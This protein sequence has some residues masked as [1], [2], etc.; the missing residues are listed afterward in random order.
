M[1][2]GRGKTKK[3]E[4][5]H[6]GTPE[7][8]TNRQQNA[9]SNIPWEQILVVSGIE[10][11]QSALDSITHLSHETE[12]NSV[13]P[14][15]QDITTVAVGEPSKTVTRVQEK[16]QIKEESERMQE[17]Q[18]SAQMASEQHHISQ[19]GCDQPKEKK[20]RM[21]WPDYAM[22]EAITDV[23]NG[24]SIRTAA[25]KY[26][27]PSSSLH[28]RVS[29]KKFGKKRRKGDV[30]EGMEH[31][32]SMVVPEK[33]C[34][35]NN[36]M[37]D[38][39]AYG[40]EVS[41]KN[42]E[43]NADDRAITIV[44]SGSCEPVADM[45][46]HTAEMDAPVVEV[47]DEQITSIAE[48]ED[49][50][51]DVD[52][53]EVIVDTINGSGDDVA[54][55]TVP[56]GKRMR[57]VT[58]RCS[59]QKGQRKYKWSNEDMV[60]A[61]KAVKNGNM[62]QR[63]AAANYNVPFWT[64][65]DRLRGKVKM[66]DDAGNLIQAIRCVR[67]TN[68]TVEDMENAI[69][70]VKNGMSQRKAAIVHG[71]PKSSLADRITGKRTISSNI[72]TSL[73]RVQSAGDSCEGSSQG[74]TKEA[75]GRGRKTGVK[76][77]IRGT[78]GK[79]VEKRV[80][81]SHE[82]E[83][84]YEE[85]LL[86]DNVEV[87]VIDEEL[88]VRDLIED[89]SDVIVRQNE[90]ITALNGNCAESR[91]DPPEQDSKNNLAV[92]D[93]DNE[94]RGSEESAV[95]DV[96][97][98]RKGHFRGRVTMSG[99]GSS[100]S[101][102][103]KGLVGGWESQDME[104]AINDVMEKGI[105]IRKA[106]SA[107]RIPKSTLA[108]RIT[109]GRNKGGF[110]LLIAELKPIATTEEEVAAIKSLETGKMSPK[111]AARLFGISF[112]RLRKVLTSKSGATA[113]NMETEMAIKSVEQEMNSQ[114]CPEQ[115]ETIP[116]PAG[117]D[118]VPGIPVSNTQ[119]RPSEAASSPN[120]ADTNEQLEKMDCKV[121]KERMKWNLENLDLAL[122]AVKDG[123]L[124]LRGAARFYGIPKS[125]LGDFIKGKRSSGTNPGPKRL[126]SIQEENALA[127]WLLTM[128]NAGRHVKVQEV[129][130]TV[131]AILDK[132]GRVI[133]RL[134]NN[135]PRQSW[136]YGFLARHKEVAECRRSLKAERDWFADD[137]EEASEATEVTSNIQSLETEVKLLT[138]K[139]YTD[140]ITRRES[141]PPVE[142]EEH[143]TV[144]GICNQGS[145]GEDGGE[146]WISCGTMG[147]TGALVDGCGV[148]C[149]LQCS[150]LGRDNLSTNELKLITWHCPKC[151]S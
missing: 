79:A 121:K 50:P 108:D 25:A 20:T 125:T 96:L 35:D 19:S 33:K 76:G 57:M 126:L 127:G 136:W 43:L 60:N 65:R 4:K 148:W 81:N 103:I 59:K 82:N 74:R 8:S 83:G 99:D 37:Q 72:R 29:R 22:D 63:Q 12:P 66:F 84:S 41:V 67:Y 111:A 147:E 36:E 106:A 6:A 97:N 5:R 14:H 129:L 107:H 93:C 112:S 87:H 98:G 24:S 146:V 11:A 21:S 150:N 142:E 131:K 133:R 92:R 123:K 77:S 62:T 47:L 100:K 39:V 88:V 141:Q 31:E 49:F 151:V 109:K 105:S 44:P 89:T 69:R 46:D 139:I 56:C 52:L 45:D 145:I 85:S 128:G 143:E 137:A 55:V 120:E 135:M 17:E 94:L 118:C 48:S 15:F 115:V 58:V 91:P 10:Q 61:Y 32:M 68:W 2:K 102:G 28:D 1:E 51:S 140:Y 34:W 7:Q 134:E 113:K 144:C 75:A 9:P 40:Q 23:L 110:E 86:T 54:E 132:S 16:K 38:D 119:A 104:S 95:D 71:I 27:V 18:M 80:E 30:S 78:K 122:A 117:T 42:L 26:N 124:S 149:H 114:V 116:G 3:R 101:R 53:E 130:E 70:D 90:K 73:S 64:L 138:E 13:L